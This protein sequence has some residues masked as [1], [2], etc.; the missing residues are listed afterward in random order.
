VDCP[1]CGYS[2][3]PED[4]YCPMCEALLNAPAGESGQ[5]SGA[6]DSWK[7]H[8]GLYITIGVVVIGLVIMLVLL[9][10]GGGSSGGGGQPAAGA[11]STLAAGQ[12]GQQAQGAGVY[13]DAQHGYS[14]TCPSGWQ[15]L[16]GVVAQGTSGATAV[17]RISVVD[18]V[19]TSVGGDYVDLVHV[20][21]YQLSAAVDASMLAV[22]SQVEAVVADLQRQ[23]S[24]PQVI[25]P[26]TEVTVGAMP[27]FRATFSFTSDGVSLTNTMYFLFSGNREYQ[28]T[29]Q[30]ATSVWQ[31]K[32]P[33]LEAILASFNPGAAN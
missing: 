20:S 11:T 10:G 25:E 19:G 30:A 7:Q 22:R 24:N 32:L 13:T 1:K 18:P 9:M 8:S 31:T 2:A 5:S 4:K 3:G 23:S 15:V 27:G 21:L 26:L 17:S 12:A 29:L 28:L 14:L 16:K 6:S 33:T